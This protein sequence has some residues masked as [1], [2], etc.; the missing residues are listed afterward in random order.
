MTA[1]G[2]FSFIAQ[3]CSLRL[4]DPFVEGV[5]ADEA[6]FWR[7]A[8]ARAATSSRSPQ[9]A[10]ASMSAQAVMDA[11]RRTNAATPAA[12]NRGA[13][14]RPQLPSPVARVQRA[15]VASS[16]SRSI[17]ETKRSGETLLAES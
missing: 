13:F 6:L 8:R 17:R 2:V 10:L 3:A 5:A 1:A 4:S 14:A 9:I 16:P 11:L 7:S 12:I 15:R